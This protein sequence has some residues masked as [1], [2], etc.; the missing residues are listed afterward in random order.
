MGRPSPIEN[1]WFSNENSRA[2]HRLHCS[3]LGLTIPEKKKRKRQ[4]SSEEEHKR[5]KIGDQETVID[6]KM[7][8]YVSSL[9]MIFLTDLFF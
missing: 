7:D 8:E 3:A 6:T 4:S 1:I 5:S 9:A 2:A